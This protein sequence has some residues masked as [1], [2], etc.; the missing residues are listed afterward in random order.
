[1]IGLL[2]LLQKRQDFPVF[3]VYFFPGFADIYFL[4]F[5]FGY[6]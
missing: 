6:G 1:M 5:W 2:L 3:F 4:Y